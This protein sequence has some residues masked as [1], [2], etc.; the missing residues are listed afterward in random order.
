VTTLDSLAV[1]AIALVGDKPRAILGIAGSPGVGK[2]TMV[3]RLLVRIRAIMGEQWAAH[4]PMDG[5]HLADVQLERLG[6]RDRKGAPETFDA[7]GYAN[8]LK[9]VVQELENPVYVPGF[10]RTLEQPLAGALVV[11]PAARL[12]I[13]EGNYLLL[14]EPAWVRARRVMAAVWFVAGAERVRVQ[15]LVDRHVEFGK[16]PHAAKAWVAEIDQ[17]NADLVSTTAINADRIVVQNADGLI[18]SG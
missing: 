7:A 12:V 6:V 17:P 2:S 15:R 4:L 5:F 9:R 10:D 1:D 11:L 16:A 18:V 13:T 8:L 14:D 3:D